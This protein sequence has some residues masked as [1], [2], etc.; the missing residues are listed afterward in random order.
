MRTR[1]LVAAL[2]IA[3]AAIVG[4]GCASDA[5]DGQKKKD[6]EMAAPQTIDELKAR[7][8]TILAEEHIPGV[9]IALVTKEGIEWAGG[10]G[11]ADVAKGS[12]VTKDTMF[13]VGSISKSFVA[14]AI[15]RLVDEKKISLDA[16][17]KDLAPEIAFTNAWES[18]RPITV[19][20]LLEHTTGF[21]DFRPAEFVAVRDDVPLRDVLAVDPR[22]RVSRWPP[23]TRHSYSN[24]GFTIAAYLIEKITGRAYE[25]YLRDVLLTPLGMTNADFRRTPAVDARLAQGYVDAVPTP[26][27]YI[28]IQHRPAGNLHSSPAELARLVQLFLGRGTIG[29]ER[30]FSPETIAAMEKPRTLPANELGVGYGLA[31][32]TSLVNGFVAH[33]H[34]GGVDGFL[35][36]AMYIPERGVGWVVL[37]NTSG[38]GGLDRVRRVVA[39]Y[40]TR[41][42]PAPVLPTASVSADALATYAGYYASASPRIELTAGLDHLLGGRTLL[43]KDGALWE[44]SFLERAKRLVPTGVPGGFRSEDEGTTR[45]AFA[46][47]EAGNAVMLSNT[48]Y[49]VKTPTWRIVAERGVVFASVALMAS[50][51]LF[52]IV[53]GTRWIFSKRFRA[54]ARPM[55]TRVAPM[56]ASVACFVAVGILMSL[57]G[58]RHFVPP[59]VNPRTVGAFV[60]PLVFMLLAGVALGHALRSIVRRH[61]L[62]SAVK[63]HSL[64][65][66]LGSCAIVLWMAYWRLLGVR[67]WDW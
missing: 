1:T 11:K 27:A 56:L 12:L 25:D 2:W 33:G 44:R 58:F 8:A 7:V 64:L 43:V 30:L 66:A 39:R 54:R 17:L 38:S 28:A 34:N 45:L 21:D 26:V 29:D 37:I 51:I 36:E 4:T 9:G 55:A 53:W 6:A 50:S 49:F 16:K 65:V 40:L 23:G 63:I 13:R 46:R 20:H 32:Y 47:D 41:D 59:L 35:S 3:L 18:T 10:V 15:L 57:T 61:E 48:R 60:A 5:R 22:S 62:S 24:P 31:N 67:L 14:L 19:A 52:A 42:M